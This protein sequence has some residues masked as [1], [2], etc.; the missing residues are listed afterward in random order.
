MLKA[1]ARDRPSSRNGS[2]ALGTLRT[3]HLL[4]RGTSLGAVASDP[5]SVFDPLDSFLRWRVGLM[6]RSVDL[7]GIKGRLGVLR[8]NL[9]CD[10]VLLHNF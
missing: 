7:K 10:R 1:W 3:D 2:Y 8:Q 9:E 4:T 5:K 6:E